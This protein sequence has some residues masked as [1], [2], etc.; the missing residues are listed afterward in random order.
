MLLLLLFGVV[1]VALLTESL[2]DFDEEKNPDFKPAKVAGL[3]FISFIGFSM[4]FVLSVGTIKL[5]QNRLLF[6]SKQKLTIAL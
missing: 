4:T 5:I 3:L 1:V 2:L 6:Q